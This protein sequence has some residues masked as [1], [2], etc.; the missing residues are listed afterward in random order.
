LLGALF[1]IEKNPIN[2]KIDLGA[3]IVF[4]FLGFL[5]LGEASVWLMAIYLPRGYEFHLLGKTFELRA[6]AG[7]LMAFVLSRHLIVPATLVGEL[8]VVGWAESSLRRLLV[9]PSKSVVSDISV[10]AIT[11]SKLHQ[12]VSIVLSLGVVT[13]STEWARAK[14][15]QHTGVSLSVADLPM[16]A[17]ILLILVVYTFF[18]YWQ[19]RIDHARVFWPLHRYHHSAEDFCV[20]TTDR[21]HPADFTGVIIA[22]TAIVL[23]GSVGAF[24]VA[25]MLVDI[26]RHVIHSRLDW[27]FGWVGRYL[28]QSPRQHRLHHARDLPEGSGNFGLCPLWDRMFGTYRETAEPAWTIGVPARYRQGAW[29]NV[30][31]WRDYV[32]FWGEVKTSLA[33]LAPF[34]PAAGKADALP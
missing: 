24:F 26:H 17:Q 22:C 9:R 3:L 15:V 2:P 10:Y 32:E 12:L 19:H 28:L 25:Y 23:G 16:L 1:M 5:V 18:D 33:K 21:R 31:M 11:V 34:I 14:L 8:A 30:D 6:L 7:K 27:T 4:G 20:L 13:I 29:I